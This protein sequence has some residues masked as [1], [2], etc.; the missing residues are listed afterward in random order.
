[1]DLEVGRLSNLITQILKIKE[2]FQAGVRRKC[3]NR[4]RGRCTFVALKVGKGGHRKGATSQGMWEAVGM[5][6]TQG[7]GLCPRRPGG[8]DPGNA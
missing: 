2:H 1:M 3:V 5:W 6:K 4:S 7:N 8:T